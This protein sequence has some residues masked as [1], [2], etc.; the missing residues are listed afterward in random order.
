MAK[1]S[2]TKYVPQTVTG[3]SDTEFDDNISRSWNTLNSSSAAA[4]EKTYEQ[5]SPITDLTI[6]YEEQKDGSIRQ[7]VSFISSDNYK[8]TLA[9]FRSP[10]TTNKGYLVEIDNAHGTNVEKSGVDGLG[11]PWATFD[12]T[13]G[14]GRARA[15]RLQ[16]FAAEVFQDQA[17]TVT[18]GLNAPR[19]QR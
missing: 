16:Q 11:N 19:H 3:R 17:F 1:V 12:S 5:N 9:S 13:K 2:I 6:S 4:G 10:T 15:V 7:I 8:V 14:S 18:L